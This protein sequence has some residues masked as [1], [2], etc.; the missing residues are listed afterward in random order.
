MQWECRVGHRYSPESL[1]D[2]QAGDVEAALWAGIRALEDRVRSSSAWQE[3]L[4]TE[5]VP[6]L[7][8]GRP[9]E[10]PLRIWSAGCASGEEAYTVAMVFARVLGDDAFRSRVKIYATDIDEH[11][12][13]QARHGAY[14][15]RQVEDVSR[16]ALERFFERTDQRYVF[17]NDLRRSVIF[18]RTDLVQ[19]A[20]ISHWTCSCA[21][22]R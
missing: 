8:A 3:Y 16:D 6:Q 5:L 1:A 11:A 13:E 10:S 4:A 22:T 9:A 14:L 2:A 19:D 15:P 17:R 20:P 12:L 7:L 21:A 18:G